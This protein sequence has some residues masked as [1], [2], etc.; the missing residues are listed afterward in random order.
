MAVDIAAALGET[1]EPMAGP[2]SPEDEMD[3]A[4]QTHLAAYNRAMKSG[5]MAGAAAAF[6]AAVSSCGGYGE[7]EME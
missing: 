1:A 7:P 3:E 4:L 6:K 2:A 5:D